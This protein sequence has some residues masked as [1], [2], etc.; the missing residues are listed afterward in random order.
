VSS[1]AVTTAA[2]P[3]PGLT[4]GRLRLLVLLGLV[5]LWE[6]LPR[7]GIVPLVILAPFSAVMQVGVDEFGIFAPALLVTLSEILAGLAIAWIG[8]G[9]IG[10]SVGGVAP[11]RRALL[12]LISSA[13][14]IPFVVV[15]PIMTA[16]LGIGSPSKIWFGGVYGLFPMAL[17]TAAGVQ[18]VDGR[19]LLAAR[20]MGASRI[21]L[22]IDVMVPACMPAIVAGLR[23]GGAL[24]AIGVV[25]A[26]MLA[27][28]DGIGF[29]ITQNRT[30]FRTAE[31]YFGVLLVLL[32]AGILDWSISRI[33]DRFAPAHRRR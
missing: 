32:L 24:V 31:V 4:P 5:V 22:V 14:A 9:L 18:L 30:M 21:Q 20:S 3:V 6:V 8:G 2:T 23:I 1:A 29:L 27:S 13:Y 25:V 28:T 15:Y 16:W 26:E 10:L 11:L 19:L 7:A 33:E 12:P 17:A